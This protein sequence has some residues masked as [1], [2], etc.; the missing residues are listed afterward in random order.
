MLSHF[1]KRTLTAQSPYRFHDTSSF[2]NLVK[3]EIPDVSQEAV[4]YLDEAVSAFY[5][6]CLLA[7]CVMLGVAAE[8]EFLRLVDVAA[9]NRHMEKALP[10]PSSNIKFDERLKNFGIA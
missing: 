10:P 6:G 9:K 7:S 3:T 4:T 1:G 2:L 5:A 8:A